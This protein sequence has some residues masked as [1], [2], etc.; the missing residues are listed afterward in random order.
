MKEDDIG[1]VCIKFEISINW[2]LFN[3]IAEQEGGLHHQF[4]DYFVGNL[5]QES[6]EQLAVILK[7]FSLDLLVD[8]FDFPCIVVL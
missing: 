6:A 5:Q 7:G 4:A 1:V 8:E 2:W 3:L